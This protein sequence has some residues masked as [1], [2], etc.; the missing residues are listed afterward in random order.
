LDSFVVQISHLKKNYGDV[1]AVEDVSFAVKAGEIVIIIGS[2]G[3]GKSTVMRCIN[4]LTAPAGGEI[5]FEGR[6]I[7]A[8]RKEHQLKTVRRR[9]GM[10][11]QHF[12]LVYGLSVLQNVL[13]GRLGYMSFLACVLGKYSEEDKRAAVRLMEHIGIEEL[14]YK[15]AAELSGGQKQRVG[16]ARALIQ[17]PSLLLCDEPIASLDPAS[18]KVVM[19][20]ISQIVRERNI[21]CIVNLHQVDVAVNYADRI[22]GIR[23][24]RVVFDGEPDKMT[25]DIIERIYGI[26]VAELTLRKENRGESRDG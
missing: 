14:L 16:I 4:R 1:Q 24:G 19:D 25:D 26:P 17:N 11:F 22:L 23:K 6:D 18:S 12:N 21:A 2:S 13:H 20:L 10:I 7:A 8:I 15:R 3:A 9:I 5:F